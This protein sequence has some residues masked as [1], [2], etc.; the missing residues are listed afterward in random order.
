MFLYCSLQQKAFLTEFGFDTTMVS[1]TSLTE[2]EKDKAINIGVKPYS[3]V[4]YS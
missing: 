2:E 4:T 3:W 1:F